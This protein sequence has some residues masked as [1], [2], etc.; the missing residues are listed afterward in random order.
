MNDLVKTMVLINLYSTLVTTHSKSFN[1]TFFGPLA[2]SEWVGYSEELDQYLVF[3]YQYTAGAIVT[4]L[5]DSR[6]QGSLQ[7]Y[8][9]R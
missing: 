8:S 2:L 6:D 7:E 5:H 4:A 1:L 9:I 3:M